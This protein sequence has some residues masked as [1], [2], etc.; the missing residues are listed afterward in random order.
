MPVA[1]GSKLGPYEVKSSLGVGGMGE[2]FRARDTRLNRD[3]AVKIMHDG[4][5][6]GVISSDRKTRF[7]REAKTVAALNHPNIVSVFD[8]GAHDGVQYAVSELVEGETLRALIRRGPVPVRKL[9][10]AATQMA[11]GL[12]AAHAAGVVHRDLKPENVMLTKDGRVKILDFGL[13]RQNDGLKKSARAAGLT[14]S[15]LDLN[16]DSEQLTHAGAILGTATYM[17]TEQAAGRE[18]D[19]QTD[20]FAFGLILYEMASGKRAFERA[21]TVETLAAL[22]REEAP[23][24]EAKIPPP[25]HWILDRCLQKDPEQR[26]ESTRDL[27]QDLKALRDHLSEAYS[28]GDLK[29]VGVQQRGSGFRMNRYVVA[30]AGSS[31]LLAAL[32]VG[33]FS[34]PAGVELNRMTMKPFAHDAANKFWSP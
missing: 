28:S 10:D 15:T 3:V 19:W 4:D 25:L 29:A 12:A 16:H 26:Y 31:L 30:F 9:V 14:A 7:E 17:S 5:G 13:A 18:V 27:Y 21:T 8:F 22:V 6:S 20:Q 11:D 33:R 23:P 1:A 32:L 24:L 2:V 34:R